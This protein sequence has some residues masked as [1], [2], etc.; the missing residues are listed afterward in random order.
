MDWPAVVAAF[1]ANALPDR[2]TGNLKHQR[3]RAKPPSE[4]HFALMERIAAAP[5]D[6]AKAA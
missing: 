4:A 6:R 1:R 5:E 2:G 3:F